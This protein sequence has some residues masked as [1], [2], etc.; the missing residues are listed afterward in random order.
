MGKKN[1]LT[2]KMLPKILRV[3]IFFVQK[4]FQQ[5]NI[6]WQNKN[7]GL[8]KLGHT[9]LLHKNFGTKKNL[10]KKNVVSKKLL[11]QGSFWTLQFKESGE[12]RY[13]K[14]RTVKGDNTF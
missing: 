9:I 8:K 12:E 4:R 10:V 11:V 6:F 2:R 7:V 3:D 13:T 14:F 1:L 5:K